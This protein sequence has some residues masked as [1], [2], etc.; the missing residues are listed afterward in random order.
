MVLPNTK[1]TTFQ[2]NWP[3]ITLKSLRANQI[4]KVQ[5]LLRSAQ[6]SELSVILDLQILQKQ[7]AGNQILNGTKKH[8]PVCCSIFRRMWKDAFLSALAVASPMSG[9]EQTQLLTAEAKRFPL[10]SLHFFFLPKL[11]SSYTNH[12]S[13]CSY[14]RCFFTP[15]NLGLI[16]SWWQDNVQQKLSMA[17]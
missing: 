16:C 5:F 7:V 4:I 6:I 9:T 10:M 1:H 17:V 14:W 3:M 2:R 12:R 11:K 13:V 8:L 15:S